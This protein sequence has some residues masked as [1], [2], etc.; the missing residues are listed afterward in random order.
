MDET[1]KCIHYWSDS[2]TSQYRNKQ[3]FNFV[4]NH[5]HKYG[6]K[7]RWNYFEAEHGKHVDYRT[8]DLIA[9][10]Y[11]KRWY[12]G[13]VSDINIEENEI[14]INFMES[15]KGLYKSRLNLAWVTFSFLSN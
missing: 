15:R 11:D 12:I 1:V 8:G 5:E 13:Q 3:M 2:P 7:A 14:E 6:I 10:V 9:A 4:A